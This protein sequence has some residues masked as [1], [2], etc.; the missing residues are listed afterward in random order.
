MIRKEVHFSTI[1]R[2]I[3]RCLKSSGTVDPDIPTSYYWDIQGNCINPF[4]TEWYA[5]N[6]LTLDRMK[7]IKRH[8]RRRLD[9]RIR[10]RC[11]ACQ[12]CR[13]QRRNLWYA[14]ARS[15]IIASPRSWFGTL[16][17]APEHQDHFEL[18]AKKASKSKSVD[19]YTLSSR[20]QFQKIY[21][22]ISPEITRYLK[23]VRKKTK[24]KLR[25]VL[26]AEKHKSGKPHFHML[27]HQDGA[28]PITYRDLSEQWHLGFTNFKLVDKPEIAGYISKYIS[29]AILCR[30]RASLKYGKYDYNRGTS[31][32]YLL[33]NKE[34]C[35]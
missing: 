29:K 18:L 14:R 17:I 10:T 32:G 19:W 12:N 2:M 16:T 11:R 24:G 13:N 35:D 1:K 3:D 9:L 28:I 8:T 34:P 31:D 7:D 27:V 6:D 26:V 22:Q 33:A 5:R 30:V 15:E 20:R 21:E 23:R 25:F 4:V